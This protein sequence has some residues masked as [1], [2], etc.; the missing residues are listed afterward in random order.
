MGFS[1]F[2]SKVGDLKI[3]GKL[4]MSEDEG[5][6]LLVKSIQV[7]SGGRFELWSMG[8]CAG[9][10]YALTCSYYLKYFDLQI[11]LKKEESTVI[12]CNYVWS[13]W[14][15]SGNNWKTNKQSGH[16]IMSKCL[17]CLR[18][19]P[20]VGAEVWCRWAPPSLLTGHLP[21]SPSGAWLAST[22]GPWLHQGNLWKIL[23]AKYFFININININKQDYENRL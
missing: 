22:K 11:S 19:Q 6:K 8:W 21:S 14:C 23:V 3:F 13:I 20:P 9:I 16:V 15:Y 4:S 1:F 5:L 2:V 7:F 18:C 17:R 12:M 10:F